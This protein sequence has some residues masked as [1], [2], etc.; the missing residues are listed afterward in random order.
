MIRLVAIK[1]NL[2]LEDNSANEKKDRKLS[3]NAVRG[4]R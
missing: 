3:N 2:V 4:F 1:I